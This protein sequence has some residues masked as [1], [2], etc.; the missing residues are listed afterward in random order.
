MATPSLVALERAGCAAEQLPRWRL[1]V[2]ARSKCV[3]ANLTRALCSTWRFRLTSAS[4]ATASCAWPSRC[5][6]SSR[7]NGAPQT[8][9]R[10]C[11]RRANRSTRCWWTVSPHTPR[12]TEFV[13]RPLG[14]AM[15]FWPGQ[16]V[17]IGDESRG[18][19]LRA[20]SIANAPRPD[21]EIRLQV[22]RVDD[23]PDDAGGVGGAT[24]RWLHDARP[25]TAFVSPAPTA[26]SSV[27]RPSTRQC[28]AF[29]AGSGLAPILSLTEAALR[30]G[31]A[32]PVTL[33]VLGA[34]G[35]RPLRPRPHAVL[36]GALIPTFRY[37]PTTTREQTP[38]VSH[39]R[40]PA[41]DPRAALPRSRQPQRI[42]RGNHPVYR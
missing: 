25:A 7:L 30:R 28:C 24:S 4:R 16:Y 22:T 32:Q 9:N 18:V 21:G 15:R 38:G 8:P 20:Y 40:I 36:G 31:F 35:R 3:P 42:H 17:Q 19:P 11:S 34:K 23:V 6:T 26:P 39:G 27:T 37:L 29:A 41:I 5:P 10:S 33:M 12:I 2:S 14:E 1:P 13:L